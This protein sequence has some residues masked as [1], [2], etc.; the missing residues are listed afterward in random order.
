VNRITV[1]KMAVKAATHFG[2]DG[3]KNCKTLRDDIREAKNVA[4]IIQWRY[5]KTRRRV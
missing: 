3:K 4:R 5:K 1:A 2:S